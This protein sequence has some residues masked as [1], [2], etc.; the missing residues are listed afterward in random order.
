[1]RRSS[2]SRLA[3]GE[4]A[5]YMSRH[6][7]ANVAQAVLLSSVVPYMLL[8]DDNP[9]GVDPTTFESMAQGMQ[10]DRAR[11]WTGIFKDFYGVGLVSQPVSRL[12]EYDGAPHGLLATHKEQL[13]LDVLAT[14]PVT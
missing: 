1:M 6:R 2:A 5:R 9:D 8:T 13:A 10:A 7:G 11:F 12:I 4:V 14:A 3:A